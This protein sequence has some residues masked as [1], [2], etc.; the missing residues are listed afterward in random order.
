ME[1]RKNMKG[2]KIGQGHFWNGKWV[3]RLRATQVAPFSSKLMDKWTKS[4]KCQ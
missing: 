3:K 1:T 2:K 4:F